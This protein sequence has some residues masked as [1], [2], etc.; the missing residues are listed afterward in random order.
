MNQELSGDVRLSAG[1]RLRYLWRNA[2]RNLGALGRGPRTHA[3][4][5]DLEKAQRIAIGQSPGRLLTELFIQSELPKLLPPR[6]LDVVEIGCGSGSMARRL[7]GLGYSGRYTGV[8][9]VD[10]FRHDQIAGVPFE[11]EFFC[12]DA[13]E[14]RPRR[15]V[16]LMISVSALEHIPADA[17]VIARFREF[18][19]PGGLELHV[20]PSG[21]GL[22]AYL[23]HGFRQYTP[24]SLAGRFGDRIEVVRLGGFG[25]FLLHIAMITLP[26]MIFGKSVRKAAPRLYSTLLAVSLRIDR[27]L[28]VC[29]TA[30]AIIRRH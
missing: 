27:M 3:F 18:L 24:A 15:G 5:P 1:D 19:N 29:P 12:I 22:A 2:L 25:S 13:H 9:I 11:I 16:D 28:P 23:W 21:A 17:A 7:A 10:R 30:Y 4:F 26:E 20:V 8:D 14:F 6:P